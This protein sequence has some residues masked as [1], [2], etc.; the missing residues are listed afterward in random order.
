MKERAKKKRFNTVWKFKKFSA[1]HILREINFG[2]TGFDNYAGFE[3]GIIGKIVH[4]SES[5]FHV[6]SEWQ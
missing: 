2:E 4:F 6:K 3:I 1:T 5:W